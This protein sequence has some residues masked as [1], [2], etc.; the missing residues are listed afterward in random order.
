MIPVSPQPE[1][2]GF[3]VN[4][5]R[6]GRAFLRSTSN[7]TAQEFRPHEYWK[8]AALELYEA[9]RRICAYSCMYIPMPSGTIDHFVA[10][11]RRPDLAYEWSNLRLALHRINTHKGNVADI[12]DPF[13]VQPGWFILDFP[14][15]LVRPGVHLSD[16]IINSVET[17]IRVLKLNEDDIFVQE[18][19]D[20][21]VMFA[22]QEVALPFLQKRYPFLAAE[23]VRQGIQESVAQI[24]KRPTSS[25]L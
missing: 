2:I 1:P 19:C 22:Q 5:R 23:I 21:M 17:T 8:W 12:V 3:D 13:G 4:V 6:R 18:R 15:C 11:S 24:F 16:Q 14:S 25:N 9:Y 10:K 20:L 7:P